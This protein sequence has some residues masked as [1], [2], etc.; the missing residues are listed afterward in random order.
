MKL[1]SSIFSFS[2]LRLHRLKRPV[3]RAAIL[4]LG[5]LI[6][7]EGAARVA[8]RSGQLDRDQTARGLIEQHKVALE[9]T[10]PD[11]WLLGNSTLAYGVDEHL[12][13]KRTGHTAIKLEHGSATARAS[14]VMLDYYLDRA[15]RKPESV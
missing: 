4:A 11:V 8:V 5:L 6:A 9:E 12:F 15:P 7:A 10:K 2:T 14:A 3:P 1:L 13:G